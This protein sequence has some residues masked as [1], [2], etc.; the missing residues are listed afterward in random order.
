MVF[1]EGK[2][3]VELVRFIFRKIQRKRFE[4]STSAEVVNQDFRLDK[5]IRD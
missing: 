3:S 5:S 2:R 4:N 1:R